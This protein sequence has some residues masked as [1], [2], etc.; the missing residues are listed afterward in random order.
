MN[1]QV[2]LNPREI[3]GNW[4]AGYALDLHTVSS[5]RLPDGSFDTERTRIGELVYQVKS[6]HDR[7]KTQP[8][9]E[10]AAR[11]V[12]EEFTVNDYPILPYLDAIIPIPPSDTDRPFQPVIE[13]AAKIGQILDI[14]VISDYLIKVRETTPLKN[15]EGDHAGK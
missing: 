14:P 2:N 9:A 13:I 3:H 7:G 15:L 12:K 6:R 1:S 5:R 4:R 10:I 8:I 11:F